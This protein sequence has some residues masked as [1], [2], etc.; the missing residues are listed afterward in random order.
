[1]NNIEILYEIAKAVKD[2]EKHNIEVKIDSFGL[3]VYLDYDPDRNFKEECIIPIHYDPLYDNV[4]IPQDELI[5]KF[6]PEEG[7]IELDE[8]KLIGKIMEL[9]NDNKEKINNICSLYDL[10]RNFDNTYKMDKKFGE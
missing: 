5:D 8:I 4:Y 1:M 3:T 10:G 6:R 2:D 7:G 9:L